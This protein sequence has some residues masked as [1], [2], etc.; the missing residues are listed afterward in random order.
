[1]TDN[2][3]AKRMEDLHIRFYLMVM[4]VVAGLFH[5]LMAIY[6][7][8]IGLP[9][10]ALVNVADVLVWIA[11][12]FISRAGKLRI[13]SYIAVF[14]L[15]LF[16]VIASYLI[17]TTVNVQWVLLLAL[18]PTILYFKFTKLERTI[19]VLLMFLFINTL[20]LLEGVSNAP[21]SQQGNDFLRFTFANVVIASVVVELTL[22]NIIN[23][24]LTTTHKKELDEAKRTSYI[25]PLTELANRRY[26]DNF[27]D[28]LKQNPH[29]DE[30][31]VALIDIDDFKKINDDYGHD[32]G[33][34][35]LIQ[36]ARIL[37]EGTRS[38]DLVCRWGGEEFLLVLCRCNLKNSL[39][40][41][42]NIRKAAEQNVVSTGS[43]SFN[44]T[45]TIGIAALN[46]S[47][48]EA[49]IKACDENLYKGKRNGKNRIVS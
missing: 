8:A 3:T 38:G 9:V 32:I 41:F 20:P 46:E 44:Y 34:A 42:E 47:D 16:S 21:F 23:D 39:A 14:K 37:E 18:P 1:M 13:A 28:Q 25:D 19:L 4:S 12:F 33:D 17:G 15:I 35:T 10:V 31:C 49:S 6:F 45:V 22:S 26:A 5:V 29:R 30:H 36:L 40:V 7:F 48:I 43:D 11:N 24:K 2:I 27:F